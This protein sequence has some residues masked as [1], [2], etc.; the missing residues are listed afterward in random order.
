MEENTLRNSLI[1]TKDEQEKKYKKAVELN[2]DYE[3]NSTKFMEEEGKIDTFKDSL[4]ETLYNC[5][6]VN[7][8]KKNFVKSLISKQKIRFTNQM[9]DLDLM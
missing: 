7:F 2:F 8:L 3:K 6:N 5:E 1:L 9:F 4:A